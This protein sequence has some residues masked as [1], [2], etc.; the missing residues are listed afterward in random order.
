MSRHSE[1]K[2]IVGGKQVHIIHDPAHPPAPQSF[3][4]IPDRES[5]SRFQELY[6]TKVKN[7]Y[8][9]SNDDT[10]PMVIECECIPV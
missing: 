7:K 4:E 9:D 5:I 1:I 6:V 10:S 3:L 8:P 2:V